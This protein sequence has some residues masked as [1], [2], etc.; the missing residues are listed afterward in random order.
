MKIVLYVAEEF[1]LNSNVTFLFLF[2]IQLIEEPWW[3]S[4]RALD[5]GA[6]PLHFKVPKVL[7]NIQEAVAPSKTC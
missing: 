6:Y 1:V 7:V 2:S 3:L 4:G 5:F